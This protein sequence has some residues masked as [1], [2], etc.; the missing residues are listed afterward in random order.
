MQ[1]L[2]YHDPPAGPARHAA[3]RGG[4]AA[5]VLVLAAACGRLP[6]SRNATPSTTPPGAGTA[7]PR[8]ATTPTAEAI[9]R[10]RSIIEAAR[11]AARGGSPLTVRGLRASGTSTLS[12]MKVPR[13]LL[14]DARFPDSYRQEEATAPGTPGGG[15]I[16]IFGLDGGQGYL[17]GANLGGEGQASDLAVAQRARTRAARQT[18]AAFLAGVW[19]AW[20]VEAGTFTPTDAGTVTAGDD[21]G[22]AIVLV[23][24]PDG[25]V[26]RLIVDP[27]THLARRLIQPPQPATGGQ[28][29][30]SEVTVTF[31]DFRPVAGVALPHTIVRQLGPMRATWTI[32]SWEINPTFRATDFE[33]VRR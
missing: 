23:D 24:G 10:G 4:I 11:D 33:P 17:V 18:M 32:A 5:L 20:L 28:A 9:A 1:A 3:R 13:H 2:L 29:A 7:M 26:G 30:V 12:V 6:H 25:R 21:A 27:A 14:I 31:S 22:A 19:P 16:T 8:P 15:F